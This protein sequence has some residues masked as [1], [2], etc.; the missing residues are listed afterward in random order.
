M[1]ELN[2]STS[3]VAGTMLRDCCKTFC[4]VEMDPYL[5]ITTLQ[6]LDVNARVKL[7][8]HTICMPLAV[9]CSGHE[10]QERDR[11]ARID[12]AGRVIDEPTQISGGTSWS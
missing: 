11:S 9:L 6:A 3:H 7:G 5:W 10:Y 2:A 8:R 12:G 1:P 4:L